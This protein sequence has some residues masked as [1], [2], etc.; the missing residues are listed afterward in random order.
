MGVIAEKPDLA[1][2]V[3]KSKPFTKKDLLIY[4]FAFVLFCLSLLPLFLNNGGNNAGFEVYVRG[5]KAFTYYYGGERFAEEKFFERTEFNEEEHTLTIYFN[6]EKT[7]YNVL[8]IDDESKTVRVKA[9]TCKNH[10]CERM[11]N[12]IYCA[13][14]FLRVTGIK[15]SKDVAVG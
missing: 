9:S 13:P 6:D 15:K 7:E 2:K 8:V 5:E 11:E 10:D 12:D 14:H 1:E 3:A 4:G